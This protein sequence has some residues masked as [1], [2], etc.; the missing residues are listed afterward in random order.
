MLYWSAN[1]ERLEVEVA[2]AGLPIEERRMILDL[3]AQIRE[4]VLTP[5]K[6][7][8]YDEGETFPEEV[9]REL[10]GPGHRT[11]AALHPRGVRRAGR[12]GARH[13]RRV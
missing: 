1:S 8:E 3:L 11:A 5:E 12:R 9:I 6:I 4:R 13:G 2:L 7:R 10:L